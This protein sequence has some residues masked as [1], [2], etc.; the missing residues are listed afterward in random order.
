MPNRRPWAK[1]K[2]RHTQATNTRSRKRN[3]D[4]K[5]QFNQHAISHPEKVRPAAMC[6]E[7][8]SLVNM[9]RSAAGK[10][11]RRKAGLNRSLA[12]VDL[13]ENRQILVN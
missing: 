7:D 6:I 12:A 3:A 9:T 11:R 2:R 4:K 5:R 8:K 13:S 1:R 10:G